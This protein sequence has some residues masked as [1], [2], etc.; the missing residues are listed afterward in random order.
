VKIRTV[1]TVVAALASFLLLV[2]GGPAAAEVTPEAIARALVLARD[3]AA[4]K[5]PPRAR[6]LATPGAL[7]S[8][9][10]L[11]SCTQI[12]PYLVGGQPIWGR[13]RVGLRCIAGATWNVFLPVQ[14]QVLAPA[15]VTRAAL[16][17]GARLAAEQLE[18]AETDWAAAAVPPLQ[19]AAALVGRTLARPIAAGQAV[20]LSDVQPHQW[21]ASG[22]PVRV[23]AVG[24]GYAISVEGQALGPG[25][26]GQAVRV[27]TDNGRVLVGRAVGEN[28]VE[29][30]P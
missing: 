14:V 2:I 4:T 28:R 27:R 19:D 25:L 29:I 23:V 5:A 13:T 24:Q 21:F 15:L 6:V 22:H 30:G 7:D 17:A 16:P 12:Q 10:R 26:E 20:R 3:A 11:A 9:L 1:S 8:R 18:T